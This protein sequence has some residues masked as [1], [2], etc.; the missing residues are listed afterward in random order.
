MSREAIARPRLEA[1]RSERVQAIRY[2]ALALVA[3]RALVWLTAMI[4][5]AVAPV[6]NSASALAFDRPDLTLP[7]GGAFSALARWDSVWY[8]GIAQSGYDDAASTAFFPLYP[9]L[10]RG[11]APT[12]DAASLLF[13]SYCVSLAALA[14]ALYLLRRLAEL[15]LQATGVNP[16]TTSPTTTR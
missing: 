4:A 8:L 3:S 13:V 5:T 10:V 2:T 9:L 6:Q 12:G 11:L 16:P 15:E 14:G 1:L 7:H